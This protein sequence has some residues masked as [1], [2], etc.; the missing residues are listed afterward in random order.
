L[1]KIMELIIICKKCNEPMVKL[2]DSITYFEC[3]KCLHQIFV[4]IDP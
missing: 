4:R 1:Q 3:I 2:K